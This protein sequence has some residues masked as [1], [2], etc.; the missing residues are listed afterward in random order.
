MHHGG[1]AGIKQLNS[2]VGNT[3]AMARVSLKL[4]QEMLNSMWCNILKLKNPATYVYMH[5]FVFNLKHGQ[6]PILW[7][8]FS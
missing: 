6:L 3:S 2:L 5:V 1:C 4:T 7:Q 8:Q